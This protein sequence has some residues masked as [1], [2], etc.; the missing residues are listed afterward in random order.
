M[1]FKQR[2]ESAELL[3]LRIL[4]TRM[5]LT[6]KEKQHYFNL[7][8]GY[9]GEVLFDS[10]VDML[11]SNCYILNDLLLKLNN[12]LFQ[13]DKL[14]ILPEANYFYEIKNNEGDFYYELRGLYLKN[15]SEVNN[16]LNQLNRSESLLRQ[17]L[18]NLKFNSPIHGS[19]VFVN[20]E[21]TL[22]QAPLNLPFIFPT[23]IHSLVRKLIMTTSKLNREHTFLAEK[24]RSLHIERSPYQTL[25][26][27]DFEQLQKGI[28]C[29]A[30]S[31][32]ATV[33]VGSRC[34][35][36]ACGENESIETAVIRNVKEF[37]FLFPDRKI[38]TNMIHEWC[39][40]V[41]S[42]KRIRTFLNKHFQIVGVRQWAYYVE[43]GH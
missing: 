7:K 33:I 27:Y 10:M 17:L 11:L 42:K 1:I 22:Y 14:I 20:P 4:N 25:P 16:P 23:Q 38:T 37:Q 24:L 39:K 34:V 2:E 31:S 18:Q 35:C 29:R 9:E 19:V 3:S 36:K 43:K 40:I 6:D 15:G 13:I 8:K 21:F 30:C 32:L 12:T 5:R 41:E 28:S 26:S